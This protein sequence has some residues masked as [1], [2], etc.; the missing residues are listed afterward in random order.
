MAPSSAETQTIYLGASYL[1]SD[2]DFQENS[3]DDSG[4]EV[5]LGYSLNKHLAF[6][7]NYLDL[8][9]FNLPDQPDAGGTIDTDGLSILMVAKYPI[10]SFTLYGKLGNLWW[11]REG[12]LG[13]IAGPVKFKTDGSN[14]MFGI[15][16]YYNI[17]DILDIK[18]EHK[19]SKLGDDDLNWSSVG[20]Y[21]MGCFLL[22]SHGNQPRA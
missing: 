16:F 7:V 19:V 17:K 4:Y 9:T 8:G 10:E 2:S 20:I 18:L 12:A 3:D 1:T 6:E 21:Y 14:L 13:S 15:G 22:E 5:N 11:D